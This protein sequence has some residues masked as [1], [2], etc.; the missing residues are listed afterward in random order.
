MAVQAASSDAPQAHCKSISRCARQRRECA[1]ALSRTAAPNLGAKPNPTAHRKATDAHKLTHSTQH[2]AHGTQHTEAANLW[3]LGGQ[4][5]V[6]HLSACGSCSPRRSK[7]TELWRAGTGAV[8][9]GTCPG[10]GGCCAENPQKHT[11]PKH[12]TSAWHTA[13]QCSAKRENK[14][15]SRSFRI[16]KWEGA[17]RGSPPNADRRAH[18]DIRHNA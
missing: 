12:P 3:A 17:A 9:G 13:K 7:G 16:L 11:S 4:G 15:S 2:T 8:V 1:S 14:W 10:R 6:S 18:T 5:G